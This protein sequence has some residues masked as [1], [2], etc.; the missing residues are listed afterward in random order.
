MILLKKQKATTIIVVAFLFYILFIYQATFPKNYVI[1]TF[2]QTDKLLIIVELDIPLFVLNNFFCNE[3]P[4]SMVVLII[5]SVAHK[6]VFP[7]SMILLYNTVFTVYTETMMKR[8]APPA[9]VK[10]SRKRSRDIL[11]GERH[12]ST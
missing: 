3:C 2:Q 1:I 8:T 5:K 9:E 4:L 6:E 12:G 10:H 7:M 11:L